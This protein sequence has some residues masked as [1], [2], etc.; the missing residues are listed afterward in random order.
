LNAWLS[1]NLVM[2]STL[3]FGACTT[4]RGFKHEIASQSRSPPPRD[5]SG[6]LRTATTMELSPGGACGRGAPAAARHDAIM[7][8]KSES[9]G[10]TPD[11]RGEMGARGVARVLPPNEPRR[12]AR[13]HAR[14]FRGAGL[15]LDAPQV[16]GAMPPLFARGLDA[17]NGGQRGGHR[18]LPRRLA[19]SQRLAKKR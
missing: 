11:L 14:L 4:T 7:R 15:G 2:P 13:R 16:L 19:T 3:S 10:G 9:A 1:K 5:A 17:L 8:A 6:R 18:G 12:A